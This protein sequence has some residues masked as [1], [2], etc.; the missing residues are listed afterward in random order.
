LIQFKG[1]FCGRMLNTPRR[2]I[3]S[4]CLYQQ[5]LRSC[6]L[7]SVAL[8]RLANHKVHFLR[9]YQTY[10][11]DWDNHK[12]KNLHDRNWHLQSILSEFV[13]FYYSRDDLTRVQNLLAAAKAISS[14]TASHRILNQLHLEMLKFQQTNTFETFRLFNEVKRCMNLDS[15]DSRNEK[16]KASFEHL[17]AKAPSCLRLLL[18]PAQHQLKLIN[19]FFDSP[20]CI[21]EEKILCCL[22]GD[23]REQL[24]SAT[25]HRDLALTTLSFHSAGRSVDLEL[26]LDASA[27]HGMTKVAWNGI[28]WRLK[29]AGEHPPQ[30]IH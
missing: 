12:I 30:D 13:T 16:V 2:K 5:T 29:A 28:Q 8:D 25:V 9:H 20:L 4:G 6:A 21:C 23:G 3:P 10:I 26:T 11:E 15:Y 17:K 24:C 22:E 27:P 7:C 18:W 1:C 14:F 19:K